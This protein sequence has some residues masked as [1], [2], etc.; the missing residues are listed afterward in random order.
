MKRKQFIFGLLIGLLVFLF[1]KYND[2]YPEVR[3]EI[4]PTDIQNMPYANVEINNLL[5]VACNDCHSYNVAETPW[6]GN[7][8]IIKGWMAS[9][10]IHGREDLNF[11]EWANYDEGKRAHKMEEIADMVEKKE[12]PLF[13]Y[14]IGHREAKLSDE[15]RQ[16]IVDW[17]NE[18][19]KGYE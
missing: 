18:V 6:Y 16:Q 1:F 7:L 8:P 3:T 5:K 2:D 12:M 15:Q 19:K 9:H 11:S 17:A 10:M 14:I 4:A 13:S